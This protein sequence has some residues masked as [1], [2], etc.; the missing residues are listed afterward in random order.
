MITD[1]HLNLQHLKFM[2]SLSLS[3]SIFSLSLSS[4]IRA[5]LGPFIN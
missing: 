3:Q 1:S 4:S 2:L 5:L